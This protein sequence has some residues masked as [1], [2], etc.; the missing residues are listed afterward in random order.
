MVEPA[1]HITS[2][3]ISIGIPT[4]NRARLL[5]SAI[6]DARSQT[7]PNLEII[8]SDNSS[9]DPEVEMICRSAAAQDTRVRYFRQASNIGPTAN[10]EFVLVKSS[11]QFFVWFADDDLHTP[12][13]IDTLLRAFSNA[14]PA[15]VLTCLE[16]QYESDGDLFPFFSEGEAFYG[17]L[18]G[19]AAERIST[20][21]RCGP[22][23]IIYGLFR[24]SALFHD[25]VPITRWIGKTLNELPLFALLAFAGS[26]LCLPEIGLRKRA[27]FKVCR[28]A[29]WEQIGGFNPNGPTLNL[30]GLAKYH[31]TVLKELYRAYDA[32]DLAEGDHRLLRRRA[33][34]DLAKHA[35][36]CAIGW[37]PARRSSAG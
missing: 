35:I 27:P 19:T 11:G 31:W 5:R 24:R 34:R 32:I 1:S 18:D 21:I 2:P 8:I 15:T 25:G 3:L 28:G 16:A 22:G 12:T 14:A 37:K 29:K 4:Y 33:M 9:T 17:G 6:E 20:T 23:N 26:I 7:Y 10:F 30:P 36:A 13:Y